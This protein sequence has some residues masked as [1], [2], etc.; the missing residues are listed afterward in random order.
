M[1]ADLARLRAAIDRIDD[2]IAGLLVE[3]LGVVRAVGHAKGDR[4]ANRLALRLGRE[5]QMLRRLLAQTAGG[6]PS[7]G[8]L[9]IWRE[10]IANSTQIEMP[11]ACIVDRR[12][13]VL[14]HDLARD[15]VG[16]ATPIED[17][18]G[19]AAVLAK[20]AEGPPRLAVLAPPSADDWWPDLLELPAQVV[21]L[22]PLTATEGLPGGYVAAPLVPEPSGEDRSLFAVAGDPGA[23]P[24][25]AR[26]LAEAPGRAMVE[27]EG[28]AVEPPD[29]RW[30][31]LGTYAAPLRLPAVPDGDLR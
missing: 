15:Q 27:L 6:F 24:A 4:A 14:L 28:F 5:A 1:S 12:G 2:Q 9:R 8:V 20:L 10:I 11:F 21:A 7:V 22:L 31:R 13:G 17:A 16:S 23:L 30:R 19:G 29:G 26:V 3:R 25:G 18:D